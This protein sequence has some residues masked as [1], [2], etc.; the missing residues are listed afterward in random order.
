MGFFQ[1]AA[2]YKKQKALESK[3]QY[4]TPKRDPLKKKVRRERAEE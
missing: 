1:V 2:S 4:N 3:K